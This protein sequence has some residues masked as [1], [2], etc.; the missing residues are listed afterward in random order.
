M[1]DE[2]IRS[3]MHTIQKDTI[4]MCGGN[5]LL[6]TPINGMTLGCLS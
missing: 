4:H 3:T 1:K 2:K 6:E 5:R